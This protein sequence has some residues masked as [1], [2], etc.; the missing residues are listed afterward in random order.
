MQEFQ[1]LSVRIK[2]V[3]GIILPQ[4]LNG[5]LKK[6]IENDDTLIT[7]INFAMQLC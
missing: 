7:L 3:A 4:M 5:V 1:R 6:V 2:V